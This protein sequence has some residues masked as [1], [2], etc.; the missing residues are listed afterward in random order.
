MG[1]Y[2]DE[3]SPAPALR[4][5]LKPTENRQRADRGSISSL[6]WPSGCST[7]GLGSLREWLPPPGNAFSYP[8]FW[9]ALSACNQEACCSVLS[10]L[11]TL[12]EK[13]RSVQGGMAVDA[14]PFSF[15][16]PV[17]LASL[18]QCWAWWL[19]PQICGAMKKVTP[20]L[21]LPLH[22][23]SLLD[24]RGFLK[25]EKGNPTPHAHVQ[26]QAHAHTFPLEVIPG[27]MW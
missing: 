1:H 11:P 25:L 24:S 27:C 8:L 12:V 26:V 16:K 17:P 9:E 15:E 6:P 3:E 19:F 7:L 10:R 22:I 5:G 21:R 2:R 14:N 13:I 18:S 20:S 23:L 4:A